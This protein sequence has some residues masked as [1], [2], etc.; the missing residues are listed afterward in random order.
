MCGGSTDDKMVLLTIELEKHI[1]IPG[2]EDD[3]VDDF[4]STAIDEKKIDEDR[5]GQ[6]ADNYDS[7]ENNEGG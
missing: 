3:N 4:L 6:C 5:T 2:V 1:N 7:I